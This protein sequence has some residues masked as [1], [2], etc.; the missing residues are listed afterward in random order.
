MAEANNTKLVNDSGTSLIKLNIQNAGVF[1][2]L[3]EIREFNLDMLECDL[4]TPGLNLDNGVEDD[5]QY[6]GNLTA[7]QV[8]DVLGHLL[9]YQ[10]ILENLSITKNTINITY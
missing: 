2:D 6:S 7:Q 9:G 1:G 10:D 3:D 8:L 4:T 5:L